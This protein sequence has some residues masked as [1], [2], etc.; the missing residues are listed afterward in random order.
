MRETP[1]QKKLAQVGKMIGL[2]SIVVCAVVFF[3]ELFTTKV[4]GSYD[5]LGSFK[6]QNLILIFKD[7]LILLIATIVFSSVLF[8]ISCGFMLVFKNG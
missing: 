8:I 3:L 6:I 1:L 2:L 5:V 4:N 7:V